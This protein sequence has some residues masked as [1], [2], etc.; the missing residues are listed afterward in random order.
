ML[1]PASSTPHREGLP[2]QYYRDRA[3]RLRVLADHFLFPDF[4]FPGLK[5]RMHAVAAQLARL[6]D[7]YERQLT[8]KPKAA[9]DQSHERAVE[10]AATQASARLRRRPLR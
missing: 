10:V 6:A 1:R 2:A 7:Q 4:A 8:R 9:R 5:H 3:Q